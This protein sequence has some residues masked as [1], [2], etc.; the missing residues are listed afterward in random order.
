MQL[1]NQ[2]DLSGA[3]STSDTT[4]TDVIEAAPSDAAPGEAEQPKSLLDAVK[5]SVLP[6]KDDDATE[7]AETPEVGSEVPEGEEETEEQKDAKVPFGKHPRWKEVLSARDA[8]RQESADW[9]SRY[10]TE[11]SELKRQ[12]EETTAIADQ[13]RQVQS[14]LDQ[15]SVSME[16]AAEAL[17]IMAAVKNNPAQALEQLKPLYS[18]LMRKTGNVLPPDLQEQVRNGFIPEETAYE[19]SR[20]RAMQGIWG[21]QQQRIQQQTAAEREAAQRQAAEREAQQRQEEQRNMNIQS[22]RALTDFEQ[23]LRAKDPDFER[24]LPFIKEALTS[25]ALAA[26]RVLTP[27]EAVAIAEE[28]YANVN[29]H[30]AAFAPKPKP[31]SPSPGG[32][33][34]NGM[35][36]DP[37]KAP[38]LLAAVK[39]GLG[40]G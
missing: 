18:D 15:H 19:I 24:K 31:V 36:T 35:T 22:A 7:E 37:T 17:S 32:R 20:S 13:H 9:K 25:K 28:A 38:N 30:L 3:S 39:A 11:T 23:T 2:V 16:E 21:E 14:Y 1:E 33:H 26:R 8:A 10:E 29:K 34:S 40:Q 12:L 5:D 27:T 6:A 4:N